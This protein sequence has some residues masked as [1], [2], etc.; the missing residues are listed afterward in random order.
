[1]LVGC[2]TFN[3]SRAYFDIYVALVH[4]FSLKYSKVR[5]NYRQFVDYE[6]IKLGEM[7]RKDMFAYID[8][9]LLLASLSIYYRE[10]FEK[11]CVCYKQSQ[12]RILRYT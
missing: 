4:S 7:L 3:A 1:M 2:F 8:I 5:A 12:I 9:F 10:D 6:R 11:K